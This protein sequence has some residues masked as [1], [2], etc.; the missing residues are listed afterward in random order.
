MADPFKDPRYDTPPLREDEIRNQRLEG[1]NDSNALWGW[2]AGAVVLALV[3]VFVFARGQ[4]TDVATN[5]TIP[6][7][8]AATN[9]MAPPQSPAPPA[10]MAPR[11]APTTTGQGSSAK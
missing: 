11:P 6:A 8:P 4:N 5:T 3:L 10:A 1:M 9:G 2:I 7:P